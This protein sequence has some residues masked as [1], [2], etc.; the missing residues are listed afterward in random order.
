MHSRPDP[1]F[2][3]NWS[4]PGEFCCINFLYEV[5]RIHEQNNKALRM[6][7]TTTTLVLEVSKTVCKVDLINQNI[8]VILGPFLLYF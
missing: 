6:P 3:L 7:M 2:N 1:D 4:S 5:V 8:R